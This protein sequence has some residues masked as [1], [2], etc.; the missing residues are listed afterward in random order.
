MAERQSMVALQTWLALVPMLQVGGQSFRFADLVRPAPSFLL[1]A[2]NDCTQEKNMPTLLDVTLGNDPT[3]EGKPFAPQSLRARCA[4][5]KHACVINRGVK[6]YE[7][8]AV[9]PHWSWLCGYSQ[10][11]AV[12]KTPTTLL[13]GG[14]TDQAKAQAFAK[15]L[16][17]ANTA[18]VTLVNYTRLGTPF[19]H[20]IHAT[21]VVE[22]GEVW[23]V[24]E[25]EEEED[26]SVAQA[27]L[28]SAGVSL[29]RAEAPRF[30][31]A[32]AAA[33]ALLLLVFHVMNTLAAASVAYQSNPNKSYDGYFMQ[34]PY[35]FSVFDH[36]LPLVG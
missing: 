35:F 32:W 27:I 29:V 17:S 6:P 36:G 2:H 1:I 21:K 31:L 14:G 11:E 3:E 16:E 30:A 19:V 9:N 13:H 15:T 4:S 24:T 20:R 26:E 12:G 33:L 18:S 25:S 23:F 10:S 22:S 8:A 28:R 34:D 5:S 7:V